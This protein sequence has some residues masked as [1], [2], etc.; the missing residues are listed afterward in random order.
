MPAKEV[1]TMPPVDNL[2]VVLG[3]DQYAAAVGDAACDITVEVLDVP[4]V[5]LLTY[6]VVWVC[7]ICEGPDVDVE[8]VDEDPDGAA[9]VIIKLSMVI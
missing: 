9:M 7:A 2:L 3:F 5:Q 6:V 8:E 1:P 4:D